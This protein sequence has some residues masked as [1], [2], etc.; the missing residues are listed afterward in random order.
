M[1][2]YNTK[3]LPLYTYLH[4]P[5]HPRYAIADNFFQAAFGGS[6]LNHQCLISA[7]APVCHERLNDGSG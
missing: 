6:F 4:Q 1:G 2:V 3:G 5:R 7:T